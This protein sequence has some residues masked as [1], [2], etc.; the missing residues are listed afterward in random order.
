LVFPHEDALIISTVIYNHKIHRAL[1]N[2]GNAVNIVSVEV[3]V[4]MGIPSSRPTPVKT[5]LIGIEGSGML[6][7]GALELLVVMGTPPK[8]VSLQKSFMI[9]DMALAYN[10]ILGRPLSTSN[11][12]HHWYSI[13]NIEVPDS[14]GRSH[15]PGRSDGLKTVCRYLLERQKCNNPA[16]QAQNNSNIYIYIPLTHF[17]SVIGEPV[18]SHCQDTIHTS[19]STNISF[20]SESHIHA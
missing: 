18:P 8:C 1:I 20:K 2:D 11:Q 19:T 4:Q 9:I 17:V 12:C 10:V 6:E 3:T 16:F 13:P 14:L 15:T 5:P 7:K